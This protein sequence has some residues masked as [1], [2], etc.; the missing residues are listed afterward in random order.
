MFPLTISKGIFSRRVKVLDTGFDHGSFCKLIVNELDLDYIIGG[1]SMSFNG[2][3]VAKK[4]LKSRVEF[5]RRRH[6]SSTV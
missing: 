6:S 2:V 4:Y 5:K 3:K 1:P